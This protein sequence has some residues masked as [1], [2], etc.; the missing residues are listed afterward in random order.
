MR[1]V[2]VDSFHQPFRVT[3]RFV[4]HSIALHLLS[5]TPVPTTNAIHHGNDKASDNP[6]SSSS[7]SSSNKDGKSQERSRQLGVDAMPVVGNHNWL[8]GGH[9]D[10]DND[11]SNRHSTSSSGDKEATEQFTLTAVEVEVSQGPE[12]AVRL[13]INDSTCLKSSA[14]LSAA[15]HGQ[16][17]VKWSFSKKTFFLE[18]WLFHI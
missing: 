4:G 3:L 10:G 17:R 14:L 18:T 5:P 12:R 7:A 15:T 1:H 6:S 8:R 13:L 11:S 2:F 16:V 9:G